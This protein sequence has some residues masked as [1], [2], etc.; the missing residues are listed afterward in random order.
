MCNICI[1]HT[2]LGAAL[3]FILSDIAPLLSFGWSFSFQLYTRPTHP[4]F[5]LLSFSLLFSPMSRPPPVVIDSLS[6]VFSFFCVLVF[7][8]LLFLVLS[9][10]RS[11]HFSPSTALSALPSSPFSPSPSPLSQL[12]P[13]VKPLS[14]GTQ[15]VTVLHR[16]HWDEVEALMNRDFSA[17]F[18]DIY[19]I[20]TFKVRAC[21]SCTY[22]S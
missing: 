13:G 16:A 5:H 6:S 17:V 22:V 11:S 9:S 12:P 7:L 18:R 4:P 19:S 20:L 21:F 8:L 10:V 3:L 2:I 1:L 15:M 14:S